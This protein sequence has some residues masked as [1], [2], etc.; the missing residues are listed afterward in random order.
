MQKI[1]FILLLLVLVACGKQPEE[2]CGSN[3]EDVSGVGCINLE[4]PLS[5]SSKSLTSDP[6]TGVP[7]EA[8]T[9]DTTLVLQNFNYEEMEKVM[10]AADLIRAVVASPEFRDEVINHTFNGVK[11]F[12]D[13]QGLS[14]QAIYQIILEGAERLKPDRNNSMDVKLQL[15]YEDTNIIGYTYVTSEYIWLNRKYFSYYTPAQVS[16]NLFHEWL[17][18]LG[19]MHSYEYTEERKYSVPY[20]IGYIMARLAKTHMQ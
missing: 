3:E 19:F 2:G 4:A 5:P 15:Y 20:A 8:L 13:N 7:N 6:L 10:A 11:M 14:N 1:F 18:K 17:H 12:V 16:G 9:F